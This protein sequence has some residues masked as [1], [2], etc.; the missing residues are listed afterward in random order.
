MGRSC[1]RRVGREGTVRPRGVSGTHYG[2]TGTSGFRSGP[3]TRPSCSRRPPA[4]PSRAAP[5][6]LEPPRP[7]QVQGSGRRRRRDPTAR[8]CPFVP[9][10]TAPPAPRRPES[11]ESGGRPSV[12]PPV[13]GPWRS[14]PLLAEAPESGMSRGGSGSGRSPRRAPLAGRGRRTFSRPACAS[15]PRSG[16]SSPT[17]PARP[18]RALASRRPRPDGVLRREGGREGGC[19]AYDGCARPAASL[20]VLAHSAAPAGPAAPRRPSSHPPTGARTQGVRR[21]RGRVHRH[22]PQGPGDTGTQRRGEALGVPRGRVAALS[23][24]APQARPRGCPRRARAPLA[25]P[26]SSFVHPLPPSPQ[27]RGGPAPSPRTQPKAGGRRRWRPGRGRRL[28]VHAVHAR[29]APSA[30]GKTGDSRRMVL[31]LSFRVSVFSSSQSFHGN[32]SE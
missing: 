26:R 10:S 2:E 12:R 3:E 25:A 21:G 7:S 29:P 30:S 13:R 8:P 15:R 4:R 1:R 5:I 20:R 16:P 19:P 11:G 18:R 23:T 24:R 31:S 28:R 9:S 27:E 17:P 14:G 6:Y 22:R 32:A